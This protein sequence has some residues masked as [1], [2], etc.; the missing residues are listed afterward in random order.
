MN[1]AILFSLVLT[2]GKVT[3]VLAI[4]WFWAMFPLIVSFS[5]ALAILLVAGV[6]GLFTVGAL[7]TVEKGKL[8]SVFQTIKEE[9]EE[10]IKPKSKKLKKSF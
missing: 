3:G 9:N 8:K 4:N 1:F 6:L 10:V 5:C 2:I 7:S